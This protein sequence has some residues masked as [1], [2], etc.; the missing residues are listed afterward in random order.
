[1]KRYEPDQIRNVAL[2]GHGG[3]GKT[4]LVEAF[5]FAS[6]ATTRLGRIEEGNTLSDYDPEEVKRRISINA[7]LVPCEWNQC[8]INFL[9]TPGYFDF[10]G[11][12]HSALRAA[13]SALV[14]VSAVAGVEVG[15]EKAM[16][17]CDEYQV[18]RMMI[19]NK[20]DRE[21]AN[22]A[23]TLGQ[24]RDLFGPQVVPIT[25]PLG[26]AE[27]F[28]GIGDLLTLRAYTGEW[29]K[30]QEEDL[31]ADLGA[32]A[33]SWREM[34]VE[35]VAST[36]DDLLAKYLEGEALSPEEIAAA[37]AKGVQAGKVIPV[38]CASAAKLSALGRLLHFITALLPAPTARGAVEGRGRAGEK[39]SLEPKPDAPPCALIFKTTADPY[40]GRITMFRVYSGTLRGESMIYNAT[41]EKEE[42]LGQL[43]CLRGKEQIP[44]P[45]VV[46]GDIGGVA[47]LQESA[48]GDTLCEKS[49][50]I[51]LPAP[52]FPTPT[53]TMAVTP[54]SKADEDKIGT[55]LARL[56]EEDPTLRIEKNT[57]TGQLLLSGQGEL[58]LEVV[59]SR[60]QKKFGIEV[61]LSPPLV[62][63]RETIR[64]HAKAEGKHKKQTG[65]RG[66]YGHVWLELEPLPPGGGFE[67]VDKIFGGVVPKQYIPAVEKG[68]RE[69]M[70]EGVLAGYPVV[71]VRV[72]LY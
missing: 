57:E 28:R 25:V 56:V 66:Q 54:R 38:L 48:T 34:M 5:A 3:A 26:S 1:M 58:H 7:T 69:T 68:V 29:G 59:T 50:P 6:G 70:A 36:D 53:L 33:A 12:V 55:G 31:P 35:A 52:V 22:F 64:G 61:D 21:N 9:D 17:L 71:D 62:P 49:H 23:K 67:F 40:V 10:I 51:K 43:F 8:K 41:R 18:P 72:T 46:A 14:V 60:L 42:R 15:T 39:V 16:A 37:L 20:L 19:I 44:V 63:Y 24:L 4:S 65:G 27:T 32:E 13:D 30:E 2:L 45:E 47:K 11:E